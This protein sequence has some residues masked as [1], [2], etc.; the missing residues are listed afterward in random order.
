MNLQPDSRNWTIHAA[1]TIEPT[2]RIAAAEFRARRF[3]ALHLAAAALQYA[4]ARLDAFRRMGAEIELAL[5]HACPGD[6]VKGLVV[7]LSAAAC[8][9]AEFYMTWDTLPFLLNIPKHSAG[10]VAVGLTVP[11]VATTILH[12]AI[13]RLF[14][15]P[16]LRRDIAGAPA[17]RRATA[18]LAMG[19]LLVALGAGTV[20]AIYLVG[21]DRSDAIRAHLA[22][23]QLLEGSGDAQTV[24]TGS[25][26][27]RSFVAVGI[28]LA[29]AGAVAFGV[30][31]AELRHALARA[32]LRLRLALARHRLLAAIQA[33]LRAAAEAEIARRDWQ[34][35]DEHARWLAELRS[36]NS[37]VEI[38]RAAA[39]DVRPAPPRTHLEVVD[40]LLAEWSGSRQSSQ[41]A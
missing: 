22:L 24:L 8:F 14:E 28:L 27:A 31:N 9:A 25:A 35:S 3:A 33:R 39:G 17:W 37:R 36:A 2:S 13:D 29:L 38:E 12:L 5:T 19:M 34:E 41:V 32:S 10:G 21:T 15:A 26:P 6:L 23:E 1:R 30:A 16:W 20:Y 7:G 40:S 4:E 18:T 11:I